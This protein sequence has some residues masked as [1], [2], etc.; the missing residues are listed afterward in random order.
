MTSESRIVLA[1]AEIGYLANLGTRASRAIR[2]LLQDHPGRPIVRCMRTVPTRRIAHTR[3]ARPE[4]PM[5]TGARV[6]LTGT[7][8]II[9]ARN[10]R[11]ERRGTGQ[12][13][14]RNHKQFGYRF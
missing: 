1:L 6:L 8:L 9:M 11:R 7:T 13:D 12:Y 2:K 5:T 14:N 3:D 4:C 10:L